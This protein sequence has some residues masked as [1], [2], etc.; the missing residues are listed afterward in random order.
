MKDDEKQGVDRGEPIKLD[1][2]MA[3]IL[4]G[5]NT[6]LQGIFPAQ[7]FFTRG[8]VERYTLYERQRKSQLGG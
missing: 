8:V 3:V 5:L 2:H 6:N 7:I 1:L 4:D